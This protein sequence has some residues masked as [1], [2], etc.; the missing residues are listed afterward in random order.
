MNWIL[1]VYMGVSI[2][3]KRPWNAAIDNCGL[4]HFSGT[5]LLI[6]QIEFQ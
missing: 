4:M 6:E 3:I 5:M 2:Y 1:I